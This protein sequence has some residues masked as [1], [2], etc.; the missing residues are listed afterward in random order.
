MTVAKKKK[1]SSSKL[2][3]L[4]S[5]TN[6]ILFIRSQKVILDSDLATLYEV[7]TKMLTRAVRRNIDRFPEDFMFQL[8]KDEYDNLRSHFGTSSQW[9]GRRY[10]PYAFTEQGVAMLSSVLRSDRAV[11]ENIEIMRTFVNLREILSSNKELAG[12]LNKLEK[13]YDEQFKIV[14]DAI[15]QLMST[16]DTKKKRPIGF[17]P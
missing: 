14:F 13:K 16:D 9:G 11:H 12:K 8:N 7:E 5:I 2:I 4:Q 17:A 15:R 3:P 6:N 10:P 1:S